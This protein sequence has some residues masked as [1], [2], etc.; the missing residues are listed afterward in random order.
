MK[1]YLLRH[2]IAEIRDPVR[3]PDDSLRPL[4][5][6]GI[7]KFHRICAGIKRLGVT[8]E[9]VVS[10]PYTRARQTAEIFCD[11]MKL[12]KNQL[13]FSENL[14]PFGDPQKLFEEVSSQYPALDSVVCVG[15]EPYLSELIGALLCGTAAASI[16]MKK[17]GLCCLTL[18]QLDFA[19]YATL[20]W[21]LTPA[22]MVAMS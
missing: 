21:L 14:T 7:E 20:E 15:H 3:F 22:Q 13:I 5:K 18:S 16:T 9:L 4:T 2:A 12:R 8:F 10:S 1:L 6:A 11:E 19:A 17:G